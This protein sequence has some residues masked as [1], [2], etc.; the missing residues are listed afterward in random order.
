MSI[1]RVVWIVGLAAG[2]LV[3]AGLVWNWYVHTRV[4]VATNYVPPQTLSITHKVEGAT[5]IYSGV[6]DT[7]ECNNIRMS[8]SLFGTVP[9]SL[10]LRL[11]VTKTP[12]CT[13]EARAQ[14]PFSVSM[15]A[16][17]TTPVINAV[18][19]NGLPQQFEVVEA[20]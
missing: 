18:S 5:H 9:P 6:L 2:V 12:G 7:E 15:Q 10:E 1:S 20:E 17:S 4:P 8:Y 11:T 19:I 16:A 13:F 14:R 3:V